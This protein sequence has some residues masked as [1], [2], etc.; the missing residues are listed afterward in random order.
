MNQIVFQD[1]S[2]FEGV[3]THLR[4]HPFAHSFKY[5]KVKISKK[6][7]FSNLIYDHKFVYNDIK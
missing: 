6:N 4:T 5:L 1:D 3:I 7:I 2:L